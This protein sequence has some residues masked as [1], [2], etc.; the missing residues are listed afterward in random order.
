MD[1]NNDA[2]ALL[3]N[4]QQN[5]SGV[6]MSSSEDDA[7]TSP[8]SIVSFSNEKDLEMFE[9][10][11]NETTL[12]DAQEKQLDEHSDEENGI[13]EDINDDFTNNETGYDVGRFL[14]GAINSKSN[15]VEITMFKNK[16]CSLKLDVDSQTIIIYS[17]LI[18]YYSSL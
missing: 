2:F 7:S 1:E 9:I 11:N 10:E 17:R 3:Q 5:T 12:L 16:R 14:M 4:K 8:T 15:P 6:E 18:S 13:Q